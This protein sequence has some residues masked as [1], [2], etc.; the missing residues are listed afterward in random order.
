ME[1]V[2][3]LLAAGAAVDTADRVGRMPLHWAATVGSAEVVA[4]LLGAVAAVD[5]ADG[6]G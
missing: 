2:A 1:G 6:L 4:A 5:T 3:G